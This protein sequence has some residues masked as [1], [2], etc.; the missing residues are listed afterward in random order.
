MIATLLIFALIT[1]GCV[2][3]ADDIQTDDTVAMDD[4]IEEEILTDGNA[5]VGTFSELN[6]YF[7]ENAV[8]GKTFELTKDYKFNSTTDTNFV[9]GVE[10]AISNIEI[11]GK[12]H[13][14]DGNKKAGILYANGYNMTFK[15]IIFKNAKSETTGAL[16][17]QSGVTVINCTFIANA[18][19]YSIQT[20]GT[21]EIINCTFVNNTNTP[22]YASGY[23]ENCNFINNRETSIG[24]ALHLV[25]GTVRNCTFIDNRASEAGAIS[26]TNPITIEN[27]IFINNRATSASYFFDGGGAIGLD[28]GVSDIMYIINSTFI[29]NTSQRNGEAFIISSRWTIL[30]STFE[31]S[32]VQIDKEY[33]YLPYGGDAI[34]ENSRFINTKVLNNIGNITLSGN[35]FKNAYIENHDSIRSQIYFYVPN[36]TQLSTGTKI[37]VMMSDDNGNSICNDPSIMNYFN[38]KVNGEVMSNVEQAQIDGIWFYQISKDL[39]NGNYTVSIELTNQSGF[40]E[41]Y[42]AYTITPGTLRVADLGNYTELQNKINSQDTIINLEKDYVLF[43]PE[44]LDFKDGININRNNIIIDGHG[45]TIS[46]TSMAKFFNIVGNNVTLK[47]IIFSEGSGNDDALISAYNNLCIENCTF[48]NNNGGNGI[49]SLKGDGNISGS[50][51]K[52]NIAENGVICTEGLLKLTDCNFT[53]NIID[54]EKNEIVLIDEGSTIMA[55]NLPED[56]KAEHIVYITVDPIYSNYYPMDVKITVHVTCEGTEMTT[57]NVLFSVNNNK[58]TIPVENGMAILEIPDLEAGEYNVVVTFLGGEDYSMPTQSIKF[59]ISKYQTMTSAE[60]ATLNINNDQI[61]VVRVSDGA[62][63]ISGGTVNLI[64]DNEIIASALTD[65]NGIAKIELP[66]SLLKTLGLGTY[67]LICAYEG[68]SYNAA[69]GTLTKLIITKENVQITANS[70]SYNINYGGKYSITLK[71][72]AGKAIAGEKITFTLNGKNIGTATTDANGIAT[73]TLTSSILKTAK[74]GS[75]KMVISYGGNSKYNSASK[76][77]KVTI[78]KEAVKITAK[79]KAFKK[80][81]KTKKYTIILKNSKGKAVKKAKVTVKIGK[82]TYKATTNTKGKATFKITKL[83]KKGKYTAKITFKTTAVYKAASKKVKITIK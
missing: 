5:E 64:I 29:N 35:T 10:I 66:S 51:F 21:S 56:L 11:D 2:S 71:D 46:G 7:T 74:A 60:D 54:E 57:G 38:I 47:N 25:R 6:D 42:G 26:C 43:I 81:V 27:C 61:Y 19:G 23:I 63:P 70:G 59:T 69:S 58:Y 14:L 73:I 40:E 48:I 77:V 1:I 37:L 12:G 8:P 28:Y 9:G 16:N 3:A 67:D 22:V 72:E 4:N 30:N 20:P 52:N 53:D 68:D 45:H 62:Y 15:N 78:N 13:T 76:T 34:I 17:S 33:S 31:N 82:K 49:I 50:T 44:E 75:K 79:N 65:S 55:H 83:T 39:E 41:K 80:A 36:Y 24:G 18:D 32:L